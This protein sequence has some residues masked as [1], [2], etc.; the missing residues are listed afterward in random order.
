MN[1]RPSTF[2]RETTIKLI[3]IGESGVGKTSLLLQFSD[4]KFSK[5][6]TTTVGIDFRMK[7]I[8]CNGSPYKL[9]IWDT[10]G[11]E[12]FRTIVASYYRGV[13]GIAMIYDVTSKDS[14]DN[15]AYW[16][17]NVEENADE[18]VNLI[19]IGNKSDLEQNR[20]ISTE[21]GQELADKLGIP[22]LET[23]AASNS[24]V[25]KMF[26]TLVEDI[27]NGRNQGGNIR[28]TQRVAVSKSNESSQEGQS[29]CC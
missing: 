6:V 27:L 21:Q 25:K 4:E 18:G 8:E 23:S 22:F 1:Q 10:A 20:V 24:N 28:S 2:Q 17:K 26:M 7:R 12:R 16:S 11:Q 3:L 5:E 14:F 9:Q 15:I 13:L 29:G 19:L